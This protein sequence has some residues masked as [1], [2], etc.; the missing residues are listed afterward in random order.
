[1][2]IFGI[3]GFAGGAYAQDPTSGQPPAAAPAGTAAVQAPAEEDEDDSALDPAEPDFTVVNMP[4]TARMPVLKGNFRLTHRFAGNLATLPF[5]EMAS[6]LFG[7]DHGAIIGFEY[8]MGIARGLQAAIYRTNFA[9]TIQIYGK[10]DAIRQRSAPVAVSAVLSVEGTDNFQKEH[11]QAVAVVISRTVAGRMAL[12]ATPI[13]V[14]NT[15]AS[16]HTEHNHDAEPA[17]EVDFQHRSTT[18]LGLAARLRVLARVY[19]VG[20]ITPRLGGYAPNKAG[21]GFGI[22]RR[23]GGHTFSL[24]FTNSFATTFAQLAR[25]GGANSLFL[26]FNLSRKFY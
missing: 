12:Y 10:Y 6:S 26:G 14:D 8:R 7:I 15:D 21:Y 3:V 23:V 25:G 24:T 17:A 22:E 1:L 13:W 5:K 16:L 18:Y 4:T 19:L 11:A 2:L 9:R 20:E